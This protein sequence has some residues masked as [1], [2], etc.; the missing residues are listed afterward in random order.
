LVKKQIAAYIE[1]PAPEATKKAGPL[2]TG[3]TPKK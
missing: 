1:A 2:K 3:S